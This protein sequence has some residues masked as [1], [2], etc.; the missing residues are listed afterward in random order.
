MSNPTAAACDRLRPAVFRLLDLAFQGGLMVKGASAL[1]ELAGG[2]LLLMVAN[3]QIVA[4]VNGFTAPDLA[5]TPPDLIA[6]LL[7]HLIGGL[8]G[9]LSIQTQHFYALYLMVHGLLKLSVVVLL[10][11]RLPWAYPLGM[12][13]LAGFV[14]YQMQHFLR[15]GGLGLLVLSGFDALM[16][17]LVAWEYRQLRRIRCALSPRPAD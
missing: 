9:G 2:L 14:G 17:G 12:L 4:A 15:D 11:C 6:R 13:V 1:A 7:G 8:I 5:A 3:A 16:I 10:A